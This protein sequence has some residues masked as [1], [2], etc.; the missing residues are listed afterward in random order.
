MKM[1]KH[2]LSLRKLKGWQYAV[3]I[4]FFTLLA[5]CSSKQM[6]TDIDITLSGASVKTDKKI[7]IVNTGKVERT[8]E[9]TQTGLKT[10]SFR[11]NDSSEIYSNEQSDISCDW[12]YFGIID[13]HSKA[14]LIN[15]SA[16]NSTDEGFTS[17]HIEVEAEFE[18]REVET[19]VKYSIWIYPGAQGIRTQLH[20]KGNG[21]EYLDREKLLKLDEVTFTLEK[22]SNNDNYKAKAI[23]E[24]P[25]ASTTEDNNQ[26]EY[27]IQGVNN[28]NKNKLGFT[29]WDYE[30]SG[31]SQNVLL[32]SMDGKVKTQPLNNVILPNFKKDH[33]G[34]EMIII[35][36][37]EEV[38]IDGAFRVIFEKTNGDKAVVSELFAFEE[39]AEK[40]Q[41]KNGKNERIDK[42]QQG[43]PSGYNLIG[44]VDCGA[45][46]KGEKLIPT[47]MVDHI[48][49]NPHEKKVK[50]VGYY[51]DTQHRNK[52]E[53]PL[54]KED[55]SIFKTNPLQ[56]TWSSLV[57]VSKHQS[58]L[59]MVKESHKCVNQY[60]NDTGGF[61]IAQSGLSNTGT[62]VFPSDIL[63]DDYS[64]CWAS[65][66]ILYNGGQNE[67]EKAIKE[68]ERYRYPV[69]HSR[70]IY[71]Q[72]NTWGSDRG[73]AASKEANVLTE[74][75]SQ[76]DLGIDIQQ[77]D[78]GWQNSSVRM[79]DAQTQEEGAKAD[80]EWHVRKDWYPEGWQNV[81]KKSDETGVHLGLW[82]AAQPMTLDALKWNYDQAGFVSYKLDFANLGSHKQINE[83]TEKIRSF[84]KYT[85]HRV[86]VNWDVTENAPRFGYF[87][88]KEYGCVYLE[89]R[90]PK[91]PKHVVYTP[92]LVLRDI[93][94][95][96]KYTN[97]NRFQTTIQNI[98]RV[99]RNI[100]DAYRYNH[101]Y[102]VAIGLIGT[103][104]FFQ[105]THLYSEQAR[106]E[107][108]PLLTV[109]KAHREKMY[110][111]YVYPIGD[112]PNNAGWTGFQWISSDQSEGY[113]MVFR[114]VNNIETE[115]SINLRFLSGQAVKLT[116]LMTG[117]EEELQ[118]NDHGMI[119]LKIV[120]KA[121]YRFFH[122]EII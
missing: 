118:V 90:K 115:R 33:A 34:Y 46:I 97:I 38:I 99:D 108:R 106:E 101:P 83:L 107:I 21:A 70:D 17:E 104:L 40:R 44:Y 112:E 52:P 14:R 67:L 4:L 59:V 39:G 24:L 63:K 100:S 7:L 75:E 13:D 28:K 6:L 26:V 95:L 8:W 51:N 86:R 88:A 29:W 62:G 3:V 79:F 94:Q 77:I 122:F 32:A 121:D 22:G 31:I 12:T 11:M 53:T 96:S 116:N 58:G 114:E 65:W 78:D 60:G 41:I 72:A 117:S 19:F 30:G 27:C 48:P 68:F 50:F 109:Y 105:E 102:A 35:N 57:A 36:I 113:L 20:I 10:V 98:D 71:I 80:N 16:K 61:G 84:I 69:D 2:R 49:F 89:N 91:V 15:L 110:E 9:L 119:D 54:I 87:W 5:G 85:N 55:V 66:S 37:P 74:L 73:R 82:G 42:I 45:P 103:P 64:W 92:S 120:R 43:A 1:I 93:W 56:N 25:V 111:K 76:M 23:A 47:G 81:V 18:Y